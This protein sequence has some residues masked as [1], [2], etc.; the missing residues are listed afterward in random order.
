MSRMSVLLLLLPALGGCS[1]IPRYERPDASVSA[2]WPAAVDSSQVSG[3]AA[4]D[5]GW[6]DFYKDPITQELITR[7]LRNNRDLRVAIL[8]VIQAQEQYRVDRSSLFPTVDAQASI[9]ASRTPGDTIGQSGAYKVR[10]YSLGLGTAN[11]EIDLFG[12]IRSLAEQQR[13]TFLSQAETRRSTEIALVAQVASSYLTWLADRDALSTAQDT[14]RTERASLQL[15]QL[16]VSRGTATALDAAQAETTLHTAEA[17]VAQYQRLTAQDLDEII[18][19]VGQPLPKAVLAC[20]NASTW[21]TASAHFPRLPAGLP[22]DV[23]L[24]RPD[25]LAAEHTLKGANA[26]IGAAR[27]AF[28]P[29]LTLTANDGTAS[30]GL[31]RLFAAG[32]GAWAVEPNLTLPIF[33]AGKNEANL[34]IAETQKQAYVANY[35]KTIQAAFHDVADALAAR[36]F[37]TRQIAAEHALVDSSARYYSLADMRFTSGAD[38]YLNVLLAQSSLFT[39]QLNLISLRLAS[40]QNLITLYKSLGGGWKEYSVD[41]HRTFIADQ[42]L[43]PIDRSLTGGTSLE[44]LKL[45]VP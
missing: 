33:D 22:S 32:Q 25:V 26:N 8:N 41:M 5:I 16:R 20:M 7:S 4:D 11:W 1:L 43:Q 30:S 9:D 40:A 29:Q 35:Q 19:L 34:D 36:K 24:R 12:R 18:L 21:S 44:G 3:E 6:R 2:K 37:Y 31:Q 45:P 17:S 15:T 42:M 23:L 13:Q 39:A 28:F 27:A 10:E 38:N 14:V